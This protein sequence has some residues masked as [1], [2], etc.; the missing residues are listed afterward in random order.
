MYNGLLTWDVN[1][2]RG[3]TGHLQCPGRY[4]GFNLAKL[5]S[6]FPLELLLIYT[7]DALQL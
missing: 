2:W 6:H 4:P 3:N 5:L 1:T 7:S